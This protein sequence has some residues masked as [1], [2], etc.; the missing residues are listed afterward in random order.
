MMRGVPA[1]GADL[2]SLPVAET[3]AVLQRNAALTVPIV[4]AL[5]DWSSIRESVSKNALE[6]A[7][8]LDPDPKRNR[9]RATVRRSSTPELQA[10]LRQLGESI[11]AKTE[12]PAT[13]AKL[14]N[15]W[16]GAN[17]MTLR[18]GS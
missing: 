9:I 8:R 7:R 15:G 2:D 17:S 14:A 12:S 4:D 1:H 11:D 10:E 13:V 6:V 16:V 5:D 18:F 3:I